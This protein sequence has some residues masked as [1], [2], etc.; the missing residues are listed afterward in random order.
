[1]EKLKTYNISYKGYKMNVVEVSTYRVEFRILKDGKVVD[2][3]EGRCV[4]VE[5]AL[6]ECR[7]TI[8]DLLDN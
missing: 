1:M 6:D 7:D 4:T 3:T 8:D 2:E 5:Q